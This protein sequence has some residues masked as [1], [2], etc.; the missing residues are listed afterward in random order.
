M[1]FGRGMR[2]YCYAI[3]SLIACGSVRAQTRPGVMPSVALTHVNIVD[4]IQGRLLPDMAI[5]IRGDRII[6]VEKNSAFRA[7]RN[8][9]LPDT[10]VIDARGKFV[11]PGLWDMHTHLS[12][13]TESALPLLLAN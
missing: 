1:A 11:I 7:P 5:V 8:A 6:N 12:Y 4:V 13:A 2:A 9:G 3:S 10:G